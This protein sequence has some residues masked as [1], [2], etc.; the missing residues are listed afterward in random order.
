MNIAWLKK[1]LYFFFFFTPLY[2]TFG[3]GMNMLR[4]YIYILTTAERI[5]RL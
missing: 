3:T 1:Y 5:Y 2:N 4:N